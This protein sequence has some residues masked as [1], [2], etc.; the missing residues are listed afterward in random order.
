MGVLLMQ[1]MILSFIIT[2]LLVTSAYSRDT[3][4][5]SAPPSIWAKKVDSKLEG[6]II[7]FV[8]EIFTE[9]GVP[10]KTKSLPWKRAIHYRAYA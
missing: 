6:P 8:T 1:K 10:I 2:I 4:I 3:L 9:L 5:V 7:E